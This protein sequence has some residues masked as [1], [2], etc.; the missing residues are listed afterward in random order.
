MKKLDVSTFPMIG[1]LLKECF[2]EAGVDERLTLDECLGW[3]HVMLQQNKADIW[4]D[5]DELPGAVLVL[6][7]GVSVFPKEKPLTLVLIYVV[8]QKRT[9]NKFKTLSRFIEAQ[10]TIKGKNCIYASE[11]LYR[12]DGKEDL[13]PAIGPLWEAMGYKK[14]ETVYIQHLE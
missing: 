1:G 13:P 5:D 8:P 14:Q 4:V 12:K 11:W 3:G 9:L 2:D 6:A 7:E 10:A